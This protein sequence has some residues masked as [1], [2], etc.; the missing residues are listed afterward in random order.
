MLPWPCAG[1]REQPAV[2]LFPSSALLSQQKEAEALAS[3]CCH[4]QPVYSM[5][6]RL[7]GSPTFNLNHV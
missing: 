7:T 2:L 1:E 5:P 3:T 6:F 4:Q